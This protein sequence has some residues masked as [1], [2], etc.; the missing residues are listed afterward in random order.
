MFIPP[1]SSFEIVF[2]KLFMGPVMRGFVP[3]FMGLGHQGLVEV[4]VSWSGIKKKSVL[5]TFGRGR[6]DFYLMQAFEKST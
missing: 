4:H 5:R 2:S 6:T 1:S 3:A